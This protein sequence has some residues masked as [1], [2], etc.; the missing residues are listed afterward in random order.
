MIILTPIFLM[1]WVFTISFTLYLKLHILGFDTIEL[2]LIFSTFYAI[3]T[4]AVYFYECSW[5]EKSTARQ[6][7]ITNRNSLKCG[8]K[9]RWP[10]N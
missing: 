6:K 4:L 10:R 5:L 1:M 3:I 8:R 9:S 2:T 7:V